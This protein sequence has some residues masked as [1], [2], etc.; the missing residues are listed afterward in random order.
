MAQSSNSFGQILRKRR[1]AKGFT[2]RKFAEKVGVSP[3]YLSLVETGQAPYEPTVK[4]IKLMAEILEADVDEWLALAGRVSDELDEINRAEP[5][6]MPSLL[7]LVR[8]MS[9]EQL[10]KLAANTKRPPEKGKQR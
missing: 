5:T 9:P 3:T 10:R 4:R 6:T 7:R 2:L 1:L 8:G